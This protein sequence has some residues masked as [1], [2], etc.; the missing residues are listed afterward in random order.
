MTFDHRQE[1]VEVVRHST[2]QASQSFHLLG[3]PKLSFELLP[4]RLI[5]LQRAAHPVEGTRYLRQLIS[6][7]RF[8]LLKCGQ[9]THYDIFPIA[10]DNLAR[11]DAAEF[12][13]RSSVHGASHHHHPLEIALDGGAIVKPLEDHLIDDSVAN[14]PCGRVALA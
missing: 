14:P 1:I 11:G 5:P 10:E 8:L 2:R 12:T 4:F 3:L 7:Q 9:G 6:S 13:C